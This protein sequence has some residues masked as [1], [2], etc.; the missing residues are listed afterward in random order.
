MSSSWSTDAPAGR[1]LV[2]RAHMTVTL[3]AITALNAARSRI[4]QHV[5]VLDLAL[6]ILRVVQ[7]THSP[8]GY[9]L[10]ILYEYLGTYMVPSRVPRLKLT[11]RRK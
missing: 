6:I 8:A 11:H 4:A 10:S 7:I 2:A 3:L 5:R 9:I 1:V